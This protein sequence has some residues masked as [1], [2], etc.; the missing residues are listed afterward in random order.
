MKK[1]IELETKE[2]VHPDESLMKFY[3]TLEGS[4]LKHVNS[5]LVKKNIFEAYFFLWALIEQ[6]LVKQL[7]VFVSKYIK[8]KIP[9]SLWRSNQLSIN[10][11]YLAISQD[12]EL[13]QRLEIGR[14][15]RNQI[16]HKLIE[17]HKKGIVDKQIKEA[18]KKD[19]NSMDMIFDRL[20]GKSQIPV[21][22]LYSNGWNDCVN[23]TKKNIDK[24]LNG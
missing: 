1:R 21:L 20:T 24:F 22:M 2:S 13:F 7:I 11:F 12:N 8:I 23:H 4:V 10:N 6:V 15:K 9:E 5:C 14:K 18:F 17:V 3:N 16:V 19:F